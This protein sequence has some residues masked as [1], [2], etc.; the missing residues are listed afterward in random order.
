MRGR[1]PPTRTTPC[2][3]AAVCRSRSRWSAPWR[4][5]SPS[6]GPPLSTGR[7]T[8]SARALH[9]R[10]LASYAKECSDGWATGPDDGYFLDQLAY[11]LV[12][13]ERREELVA[14]VTSFDWIERRLTTGSLAALYRDYDACGDA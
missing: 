9:D 8:P 13:A 10:L 14:L 1:C 11:H 3:N 5:G 4:A 7:R 2:A 12:Q 6:A